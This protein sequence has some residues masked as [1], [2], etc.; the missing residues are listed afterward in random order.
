MNKIGS[1]RYT[2]HG[3]QAIKKSY[4]LR[5]KKKKWN[6]LC[7][8]KWQYYW[9]TLKEPEVLKKAKHITYNL[10]HLNTFTWKQ[11]MTKRFINTLISFSCQYCPGFNTALK[12]FQVR[13]YIFQEKN[14]YPFRLYLFM[15]VWCL[16]VYVWSRQSK[17]SSW[18]RLRKN[19][20]HSKSYDWKENI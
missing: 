3:S 11:A 2:C 4:Q 18:N 19:L 15:V 10:S 8:E 14:V 13:Q 5:K 7:E 9:V 12:S 20:E 17:T 1:K 6:K 16:P